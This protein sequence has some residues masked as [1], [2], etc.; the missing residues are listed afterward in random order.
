M[1]K[2][3]HW[4]HA[5]KLSI[6]S[7]KSQYMLVTTIAK[8]KFDLDHFKISSNNSEIKRN[9]CIKYLGV[10]IDD[11][12]CWKN[13]IECTCSKISNGCWM[14]QSLKNILPPKFLIDVYYSL[15]CRRLC[16]CITSWGCASKTR[17]MPLINLQKRAVCIITNKRYK[18]HTNPLFLD[19]KVLKIAEIYK[20]HKNILAISDSTT[21]IS[22]ATV[23]HYHTRYRAENFHRKQISKQYMKKY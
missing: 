19:C 6:N 9:E 7:T 18:D 14:L 22:V 1:C 4:L 23:H 21:F 2:T 16:Y 5:N 15:I 8:K 13:C 17:L 11:K 3:D 12:L 10:L 20:V